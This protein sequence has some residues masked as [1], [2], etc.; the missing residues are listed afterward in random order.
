MA[1][2]ESQIITSA[3]GQPAQDW[4]TNTVFHTVDIGVDYQNHANEIRDL[5]AGNNPGTGGS[6]KIYHGAH[7]TVKVYD[8]SDPPHSPPRATA[9]TPGGSDTLSDLGP[10]QVALCL[11]F[12][13]GLNVKSKRGRIY[14]GPFGAGR[15]NVSMT[16]YVPGGGTMAQILDLG[17]GLFDIGGE[18]VAHVIHSRKLN[19]DFVVSDYWVDNRWDTVRSRLPKAGN[20]VTLHP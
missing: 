6:F 19:Q 18:N 7:L 3:T 15:G 16:S 8:R 10:S 2:I 13:A 4:T 11:S 1:L 20:R 5:F 17:H 12:F 9:S 14:I